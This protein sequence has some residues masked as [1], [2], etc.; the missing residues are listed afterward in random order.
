M[1]TVRRAH[2]G[3]RRRAREHRHDGLLQW[4]RHA[5]GNGAGAAD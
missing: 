1:L 2:P 3:I 4:A 5:A